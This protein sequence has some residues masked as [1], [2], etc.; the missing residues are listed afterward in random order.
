MSTFLEHPRLC[1]LVSQRVVSVQEQ[2]SLPSS[3]YQGH[4]LYADTLLAFEKMATHSEKR[5][6]TPP[7][8]DEGYCMPS[9]PHGIAPSAAKSDVDCPIPTP[10]TLADKR[11]ANGLTV[12]EEAFLAQ[13]RC[14]GEPV[15]VISYVKNALSTLR[16]EMCHAR[17]ALEPAYRQACDSAWNLYSDK[18]GKWSESFLFDPIGSHNCPPSHTISLL[19]APPQCKILDITARVMPTSSAH[20]C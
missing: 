20:M 16:H 5:S 11:C 8:M 17:Y 13:W 19:H 2:H 7:S 6:C 12:M 9:V 18:L 15:V 1:S 4:N 10:D 3:R 14:H